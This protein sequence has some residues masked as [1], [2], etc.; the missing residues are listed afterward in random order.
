MKQVILMFKDGTYKSWF[1]DSFEDAVESIQL[2]SDD[3]QIEGLQIL[4]IPIKENHY[5]PSA[6]H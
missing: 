6:N 5:V 3:D 2:T 4:P 1:E